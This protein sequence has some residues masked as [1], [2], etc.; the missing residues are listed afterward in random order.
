M[1][2]EDFKKSGVD[3][4][5]VQTALG[6]DLYEDAMPGRVF[7]NALYIECRPGNRWYTMIIRDEY[8]GGL[9]DVLKPLY[10]YA[11]AEGYVEAAADLDA[12]TFNQTIR[13]LEMLRDAGHRG[14]TAWQ[15]AVA[16][17]QKINPNPAT[18]V[19]FYLQ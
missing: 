6:F 16:H 5:D 8:E 15:N 4:D 12:L 9:D 19:G 7:L 10:D 3:V 13:H 1:N 11:I 2:Y 18:P 14:T 17:A